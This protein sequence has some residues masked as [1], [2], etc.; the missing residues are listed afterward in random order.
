MTA[1]ER[2]AMLAALHRI[3]IAA[4]SEAETVYPPGPVKPGRLMTTYVVV[5]SAI[6]AEWG[7]L[8]AA[9]VEPDELREALLW[10][11]A[12]LERLRRLGPYGVLFRDQKPEFHWAT[13]MRDDAAER[14]RE[15]M[16]VADGDDR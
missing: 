2:D 6:D 14:V 10:H 1:A 15:L 13:I 3:R 8:L 9:P 5:Q 12:A 4:Q 7:R 11:W 16:E